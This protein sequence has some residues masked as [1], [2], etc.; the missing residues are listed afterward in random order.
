MSFYTQLMET[1]F[2]FSRAVPTY[3][4]ATIPGFSVL[5]ATKSWMRAWDRGY[6]WSTIV[7]HDLDTNLRWFR[8]LFSVCSDNKVT[9]LSER[10]SPVIT[11]NWCLKCLVLSLTSDSHSSDGHYL[12]SVRYPDNGLGSRRR[13][14]E[15]GAGVWESQEGPKDQPA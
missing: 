6:T 12:E 2:F 5:Q 11:A 9:L 3:G 4:V 15:N 13:G 1:P 14:W 7:L 10:T 8:D